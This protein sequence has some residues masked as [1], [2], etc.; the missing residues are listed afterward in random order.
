MSSA[1]G[2]H[3]RAQSPSSLAA[4]RFKF[5]HP[6]FTPEDTSILT[7]FRRG[8]FSLSH[9]EKT[10]QNAC[11]LLE[12]L[13]AR[14]GFPRRTIATAQALYHRF[15]LY[16]SKKDFNYFDVC[17]AALYVSTKMHDTL[18]KPREL[19][20]VSYAV[21]FPELAAKSKHPGGE[22]DLDSM[23]PQ[24]VESDRQRLL[25]IERLILETICFNFKCRLPFS[26]VIKIGRQLRA[27]KLL[28]KLAWRLVM[29][30]YRTHLPLEFP[31][32]TLALGGLFVASLL[33]CFEQAPSDTPEYAA[34]Q[35]ISR[36]LRTKG[37]WEV[38]FQSQVADMQ[39]KCYSG[40]ILCKD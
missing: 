3:S 25:A 32:H 21:R 9:D 14:I 8:K 10:R 19:M 31:P 15:H 22:I 34:A 30:C 16:F 12:V 7:N 36:K 17:L 6:Y 20:A 40:S 29:D 26:Y 18:K 13:G 37:D 11:G 27:T 23:D 5:Y 38:K 39:G 2:G 35:D 4:S 24:V 1:D 28:T 33:T